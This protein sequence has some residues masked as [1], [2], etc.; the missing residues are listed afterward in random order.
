[1]GSELKVGE[2]MTP[3]PLAVREGDLATRVR[4]LFRSSGYKGIPVV[5]DNKRVSG[6]IT[7]GNMLRITSTRSNLTAEGI[8]ESVL[9]YL[10]PEEG[11]MDGIKK[12]MGARVDR[13]VVVD[14]KSTMKLVGLLSQHDAIDAFKNL[15][16]TTKTRVEEFMTKD[17]ITC[18]PKE[19]VTRVWNK[20]LEG[21]CWG[22]PVVDKKVVGMITGGDILK[23]GYARIRKEND[24]DLSKRAPAVEKVMHTPAI[25][26]SPKA[27]M[28]EAIEVMVL[29][30]IGRLPVV[31]MDKLQGIID[32][33]DV[34]T[35]L[36]GGLD[37]EN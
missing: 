18:T 11:L 16:V 4:A 19:P 30:S 14:T 7:L 32:R 34:L 22:I 21:D 5:A 12:M 25:T 20:M 33:E 23:A 27:T 3:S 35:K 15:N 13:A 31:E 6:M 8:M 17:V 29:R 1:V 26:I 37:G 24:K 36:L 9:V 10:T 28:K 2:V